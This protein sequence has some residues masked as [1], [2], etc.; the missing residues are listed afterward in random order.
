MVISLP[1]KFLL[2][3][4][5]LMVVQRAD[6]ILKFITD[7]TVNVEGVGHVCRFVIHCNSFTLLFILP[8]LF[9]VC[10]IIILEKM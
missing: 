4:D 9:S 6:D 7:F 8:V 1:F 10:I 5:Q 2:K 3:R